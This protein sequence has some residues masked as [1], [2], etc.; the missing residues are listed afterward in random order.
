MEYKIALEKT[1]DVLLKSVSTQF[2]QEEGA[3]LLFLV[4][5]G[6]YHPKFQQAV[7]IVTK[8][9]S[10]NITLWIAIN[11]FYSQNKK[12]I[13]HYKNEF[14]CLV[15]KNNLMIATRVFVAEGL[16]SWT[17]FQNVAKFN[18]IIRIGLQ[19]LNLIQNTKLQLKRSGKLKLSSE[20][21]IYFVTHIILLA[22]FYGER[23]YIFDSSVV[24]LVTN[25]MKIVLPN[26]NLE[27]WLE[28]SICMC[29]LN[30]PIDILKTISLFD[31]ESN[32]KNN[33]QLYH[34]F[35]LWTMLFKIIRQ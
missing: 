6:Y 31:P 28:L 17:H 14:P 24:D 30:Q 16:A 12:F 7:A 8:Q 26:Q 25:W 20:Y 15:F 23:I 35:A 5:S 2:I 27:I 29:L 19:R 3:N 32:I 18:A 4:R 33:H 13:S 9:C 11:G 1:L 22:T 34:T 10:M 21:L